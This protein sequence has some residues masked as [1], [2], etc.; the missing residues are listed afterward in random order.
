MHVGNKGKKVNKT[1][2]CSMFNTERDRERQRERESE[3]VILKIQISLLATVA[4][5]LKH[6]P[7]VWSTFKMEQNGMNFIVECGLLY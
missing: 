5:P 4:E 2:N 7:L 3:G 1:F 6:M